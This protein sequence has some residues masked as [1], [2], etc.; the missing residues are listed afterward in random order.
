[1]ALTVVQRR[2]GFVEAVHPFSVV[3][4]GDG[5]ILLDRGAPMR[6]PMR[7]SAKPFQLACALE[8][9]G[10]PQLSSAELAVGAA[11]H[12]AEPE[13]VALVRGL[14]ERFG[15]AEHG[16]LCGGHA[17]LYTGAWE[18]LIRQGQPISAIHN[19]CSG[20]HTFMRAASDHAGWDHD[21][22]DPGH[23]LQQRI[24]A[25]MEELSGE[26]PD[27]AIDGCGAPSWVLRLDSMARAWEQLA[28]GSDPRVQRVAE[29]MMAN[30]RLTSGTGRLD[31]D[32]MRGRKEPLVVK[33]GAQA[34]FCMALPERRIGIAVKVHSGSGP[35][36]GPAVAWALRTVAPGAWV[37][38]A[39]W[40]WGALPNV[41]G[42]LVG[43]LRVEPA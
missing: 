24:A 32:V 29:A 38:P 13:H 37:E 43:E 35:A 17:P 11:S 31:L 36:L 18:E 42:K 30:P 12:T 25:M 34:L 40:A 6:P 28:R 23:P 1:M 41:I 26:R 22:R 2:G 9:L 15:V 20:K 39:A 16:L 21:Y 3:A 4:V 5:Q 14:M 33:I 19:N 27:A 10:D 8:V 7:S